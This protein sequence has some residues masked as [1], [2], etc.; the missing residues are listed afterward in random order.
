MEETNAKDTPEIQK[1]A[2]QQKVFEGNLTQPDIP[3][4]EKSAAGGKVLV[5]RDPEVEAA[6]AG[7]AA[8]SKS[9]RALEGEI[10]NLAADELGLIP[11]G[12]KGTVDEG[13]IDHLEEKWKEMM[14]DEEFPYDLRDPS[15][16]NRQM[17]M[18][19]VRSML[20]DKGME[21]GADS[22]WEGIKSPEI[23]KDLLAWFKLW[24]G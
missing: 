22:E 10:R 6:V 15:N 5:Q 19:H 17:D 4:F 12:D 13:D 23:K 8:G 3:I 9:S 11:D 24:G 14:P 7:K 18:E 20:E 2:K 16:L 21:L 1:L